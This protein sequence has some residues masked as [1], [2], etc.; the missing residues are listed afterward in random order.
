MNA[1]AGAN[2][3]YLTIT[4]I[5]SGTRAEAMFPKKLNTPPVRPI[6]RFGASRDTRI[7]VIE[8][9]PLQKKAKV[10]KKTTHRCPVTK[11][12][13]TTL[14]DRSMPAMIG[15]LRANEADT[16]RRTRK[17]EQTPPASTPATAAR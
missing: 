4:P 2:P 1:S 5:T 11:F 8:A 3:P 16:P 13:P 6:S 17:S 15:A 7:H 14:V 9:K 12:A 10:K